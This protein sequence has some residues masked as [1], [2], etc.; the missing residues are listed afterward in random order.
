MPVNYN[1]E[2]RLS[3]LRA[4]HASMLTEEQK[5]VTYREFYNGEQGV[6]LSDRQDDYLTHDVESF[7][8]ICKRVV[9]IPKDRLEVKENG[10]QSA[11]ESSVDFA[12]TATDWWTRNRLGAKQKEVYEA[13][14]RDSNA[15]IIVSYDTTKQMPTFTPNAI[16]DG[17]SGL[18]RFHYDNDDNLLFASKRWTTWN[19][20]N[21]TET[22][23]RRMTIYHPD[24]IERYE[25]TTSDWRYLRPDEIGGLPNPQIWTMDGTESG[26]P[27][28]IP[29]VPFENPGGSEL[30]DVI[31]IQELFNHALGTFDIATDFHG[32][33]LLWFVGLDLPRDSNGNSY[34]PDFSPGQG[35]NLKD[36]GKAGRIET[37][38]LMKMFE[39]GTLSWI[40]VLAI[41]KGWPPYLLQNSGNIP[42]GIALRILE[43]GLVK[44][45]EDKQAVFGGAWQDAFEIAR[46]LHNI[47]NKQNAQL[48]GQLKIE[49]ESAE[50]AD[51]L[52]Q[53]QAQRERFESGNIPT[54]SRWR[55]MGFTEDDIEQFLE[56][57][58]REDDFGGMTSELFGESDAT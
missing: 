26:E 9:N 45:V 44:Q 23:K 37:A 49:W 4:A 53:A 55:L 47:N 21:T 14:L 12:T 3:Y 52:A 25:A 38:D 57:A 27:I 24:L 16:Y 54:I 11:D 41:I 13:S 5:I 19:P 1:D 10:I 30:A 46:R 6:L 50:T 35:L 42:S 39:A 51:D 34:M 28:G 18:V 48:E 15:G 36:N 56:D 40:Q 8:N 7:G 22:G 33:P 29:A 17:Q 58:Q 32:W 43:G 2:L 20:V 31:N